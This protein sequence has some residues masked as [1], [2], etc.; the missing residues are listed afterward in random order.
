M[1]PPLPVPVRTCGVAKA[2][3]A[4]QSS[5]RARPPRADPAHA[6]STETHTYTTQ[7]AD[8]HMEANK[9]HTRSETTLKARL[10]VEAS[11]A[12]NKVSSCA[13]P[14]MKRRASGG[15]RRSAA[16]VCV[17]ICASCILCLKRIN[18]CFTEKSCVC[19][20]IVAC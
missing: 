12:G 13:A 6:A 3:L 19:F 17:S 5:Q 10:R 14:Q 4:Q 11:T 9:A 15:L 2:E 20:H 7:L 1:A 8:P 18:S 16:A